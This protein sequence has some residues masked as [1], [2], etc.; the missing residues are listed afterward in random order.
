MSPLFAA[1]IYAGISNGK[2]KSEEQG[3]DGD[4][5]ESSLVATLIVQDVKPYH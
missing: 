5:V 1:T 2:R 3:E 4:E